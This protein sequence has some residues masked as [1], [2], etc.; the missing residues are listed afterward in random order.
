MKT[1]SRIPKVCS[2]LVFLM[3]ILSIVNSQLVLARQFGFEYDAAGNLVK[4]LGKY[5]EYDAFNQLVKVRE[6]D[7]SGRVVEEYWYDY[8]GSRVKKVHYNEDGS[9]ETFY[10]IGDS[11]VRKVNSSGTYDTNYHYL[12]SELVAKNEGGETLFFHPDHLGSTSLITDESGNVVEK[13]TYLPFGAVFEGGSEEE[14]LYTGKEKDDT[15]LMYYGA[16][17][18][19]PLLMKFTQP[20][21][22]LP[23]VYDP[24]QLNRYS[25]ARN[26]PYKYT[27]PTGHV[28]W[29][30]LLIPVVLAISYA[31][32]VITSALANPHITIPWAMD[33]IDKYGAGK[34]LAV[35]GA[36]M[37][38]GEVVGKAI[39]KAAGAA[40]KWAKNAVSSAFKKSGSDAFKSPG[41]MMESKAGSLRIGGSKLDDFKINPDFIRKSKQLKT[42]GIVTVNSFDEANALR[43]YAFPGAKKVPGAG[44]KTGKA[45][46]SVFEKTGGQTI[47][48]TDYL[49]NPETNRVYGESAGSAHAYQPHINIKD[50]SGNSYTILIDDMAKVKK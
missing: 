9:K 4:G 37:A 10:Y 45:G 31:V 1:R 5:Y 24:Q 40:F 36:E 38:T 48:K 23:D 30:V 28:V 11:F 41:A 17:Y 13:T 19:S 12:G 35:T 33:N 14:R 49:I 6:N 44:P 50:A 21:T 26:N 25:Y 46:E 47:Y 39:G 20:D 42:E 3:F 18:Y 29:A 27:D 8:E 32:P 2:L 7:E 16:R 15:G 34:G 43:S 22:I